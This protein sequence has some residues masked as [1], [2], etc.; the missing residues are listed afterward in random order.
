MLSFDLYSYAIKNTRTHNLYPSCIKQIF[1][2]NTFLRGADYCFMWSKVHT[3][4]KNI[5]HYEGK[6]KYRWSE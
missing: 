1:F 4:K 3:G 2:I 6:R 5:S